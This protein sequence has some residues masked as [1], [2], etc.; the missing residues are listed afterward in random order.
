M[1]IVSAL[2]KFLDVKGSVE[3]RGWSNEPNLSKIAIIV[4]L[5][6]IIAV[7]FISLVL[8]AG[9]WDIILPARK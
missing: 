8:W 1:V 9:L 7:I 4:F 3:F 2:I 6:P 5:W